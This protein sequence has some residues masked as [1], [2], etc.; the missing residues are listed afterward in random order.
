MKKAELVDLVADEA[1]ITKAD[2][3]KAVDAVFNGI[4][5]S[6]KKDEEVRI[7][8]FGVF[9]VSKSA[10][11]KARNPRNGVEVIV[12]PSKRPRFRAGKSLKE[13]LNK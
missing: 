7:S 13:E 12:P 8:G 3:G 1:G 6:L 9:G 4:T 5:N 10:G 2:A 11:G